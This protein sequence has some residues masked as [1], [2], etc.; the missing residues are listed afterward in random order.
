VIF[1]GNSNAV[2]VTVP[3]RQSWTVQIRDNKFMKDDLSF[4][5]RTLMLAASSCTLLYIK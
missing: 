2:K 4:S 1:N 3:K 5:E